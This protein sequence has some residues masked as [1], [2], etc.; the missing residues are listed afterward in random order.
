M[1]EALQSQSMRKFSGLNNVDDATRLVPTIDAHEY[2][3]PLTQANN[4]EIDNTF[5]LSSRIGFTVVAGTAGTA[6]IDNHSLWSDGKTCLYVD[7]ASFY[8]MT[9]LYNQISLR[10]DLTRRAR[11]S[12][13]SF[14]DRIY[15]TNGYQIGYVKSSINNHLPAPNR[16]FK[17]PLPAG[18]LIEYFMGCLYIAKDNILYFSDPLCDYYDIRTGYRIFKDN[19]T[20]L[21]AVDDGLYVSDSRIWFVKGRG[22]EDFNRDE[23]YPSPAI[24]YTDLRVI[25]KYIDDQLSGNV[26]MWTSENGICLGN[27]SGIVVNLTESRYTF[28]AKSK[29]AAVIREVGNVRHYVNSL[30]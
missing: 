3:Y 20:M 24:Q 16:E 13:A 30:Y 11:M 5:G 29:G 9:S 7:G 19:I 15:Y 2:V 12:Y 28:T 23:V 17:E 1:A 4:V 21:R 27:N 26:A 22:A 14:N 25:G 6:G 8:E 10:S 18:Q